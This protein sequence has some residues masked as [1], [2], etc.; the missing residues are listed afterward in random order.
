MNAVVEEWKNKAEGDYHTAKREL[1]VTSHPNYDA[2]C[3]HAQQCVEKLLK[4]VLIQ[5]GVTPPKAHDLVHLY[6][7]LTASGIT[8]AWTLDDLR[9]LTQAAVD[10]RYPGE[11]ATFEQA[12]E[13]VAIC[14]R[15]RA[16]MLILL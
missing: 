6:H 11:E 7:L 12:Q 8:L 1:D 10:F 16:E 15:M 9:F 4:A 5:R 2:V 13:A 14:E 3:F